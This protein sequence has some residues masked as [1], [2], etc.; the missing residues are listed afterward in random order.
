LTVGVRG[1]GRKD[2]GSGHDDGVGGVD[3]T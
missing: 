3:C 2:C 1:I